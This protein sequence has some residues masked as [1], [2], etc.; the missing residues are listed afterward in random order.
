MVTLSFSS[1]LG[2]SMKYTTVIIF[3][4]T[5]QSWRSTTVTTQIYKP[6]T[7]R[8]LSVGADEKCGVQADF[9]FYGS[10]HYPQVPYPKYINPLIQSLFLPHIS[11]TFKLVFYNWFFPVISRNQNFMCVPHPAGILGAPVSH[12]WFD[13]PGSSTQEGNVLVS[14]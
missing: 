10:S 9:I 1:H 2:M 6:H 14:E 5:E 4:S 11:L 13:C 12:S 7:P 3:W 8:F